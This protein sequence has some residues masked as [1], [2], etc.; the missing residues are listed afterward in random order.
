[1]TKKNDR[2]TAGQWLRN[3]WGSVILI[4]FIALMVFSPASKAWVMQQLLRTGL[5]NA[6]VAD[7]ERKAGPG[8]DFSLGL[9]DGRTIRMSSLK[10]KVVFINFW[11]SWC[12]PCRAEFPGMIKLYNRFKDDDRII[13]LFVN[14]DDNLQTAEEYL[15]R[16]N[17]QLPLALNQGGIPSAIYSGNLP[18]TIVLDK[19][20]QLRYR[21]EG[22][23][24]YDSP[25]FM[26][27]LEHLVKE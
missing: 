21:H 13:F 19:T 8:V 23:A 7:T 15:N 20:G 16:E 14:E 25:E 2:T 3:H 12:P 24:A 10:G 5:F 22:F 11:A 1:M 17:Y 6:H 4:I 9:K 18:T 26:A 27:Q